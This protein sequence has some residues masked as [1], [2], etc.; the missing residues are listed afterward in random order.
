MLRMRAMAKE[1]LIAKALSQGLEP[2][3][4]ESFGK[5]ASHTLLGHADE[6]IALVGMSSITWVREA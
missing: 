5:P 2:L 4:A 3:I 6:R 1:H